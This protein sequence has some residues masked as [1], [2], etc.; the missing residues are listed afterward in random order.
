MSWQQIVGT[1]GYAT[2]AAGTATVPAGAVV[3]IISAHASSA[4]ATVAIFGGAAIPVPS[5]GTQY[6]LLQFNH[7]LFQANAQNG[8]QIVFTN[9]DHYFVH[10]IR[11]GNT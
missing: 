1:P 11:Q 2:G 5:A 9:T 4:S 10:W 6:L 3:H 7:T 8:G